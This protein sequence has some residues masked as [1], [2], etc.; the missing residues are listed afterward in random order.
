MVFYVTDGII[1]NLVAYCLQFFTF[2]IIRCSRN[3]KNK[4]SESIKF[5]HQQTQFFSS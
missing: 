4:D 5:I 2:Y 1:S 3:P